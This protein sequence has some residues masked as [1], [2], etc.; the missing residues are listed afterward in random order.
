[1]AYHLLQHDP[2]GARHLAHALQEAVDSTGHCRLCHTFSV[3]PVCAVCEDPQRDAGLLCV[4]E[5][6]ADQAALERTGGFLGRYFVLLGRLQPLGRQGPSDLGF[7]ELLER[8]RG[9]D[10]REII[11][12]TSFTA[13]GEATA[14]ALSAAIRSVRS[15]LE[16]T[17]LA[18]GVPA[19]SEIEY[20]DSS[21]I[22]HALAHRR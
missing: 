9:E 10:L 13:E 16:V 2:G 3:S 7:S 17:R 12:A 19:G 22:A 4:V 15:D 11:L 5:T 21:T 14:Q 18:R 6:P 20:V 1:M 8:A